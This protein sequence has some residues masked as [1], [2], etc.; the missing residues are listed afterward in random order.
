MNATSDSRF[1]VIDKSIFESTMSKKRVASKRK[2]PMFISLTNSSLITKNNRPMS[3]SRSAQK[4]ERG[5]LRS[6]SV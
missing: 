5:K 4:S 3:R 1:G 6:S 2:N